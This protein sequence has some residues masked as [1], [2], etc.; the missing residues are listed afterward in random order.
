VCNTLK[1]NVIKPFSIQMFKV[2]ETLKQETYQWAKGPGKPET[3]NDAVMDIQNI[4]GSWTMAD[5]TGIPQ[6]YDVQLDQ[7]FELKNGTHFYEG[8]IEETGSTPD[9][10]TEPSEIPKD[11]KQKKIHDKFGVMAIYTLEGSLNEGHWIFYIKPEFVPTWFYDTNIYKNKLQTSD[12]DKG[13]LEYMAFGKSEDYLQPWGTNSWC[14]TTALIFALA[15]RGDEEAIKA[16][17][18][19]R[20]GEQDLYDKQ[21]QLTKWGRQKTKVSSW[22]DDNLIANALLASELAHQPDEAFKKNWIVNLHFLTYLAESPNF[23]TP[24]LFNQAV[25]YLAAEVRNDLTNYHTMHSLV[26]LCTYDK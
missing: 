21:Y 24:P 15:F 7:Y 2:S 23:K 26:K 6:I 14:Q 22:E 20:I 1:E 12:W 16:V 5:I 25:T 19:F 17:K 8:D 9:I 13:S 4:V 18:E 11:C 10:T 3:I